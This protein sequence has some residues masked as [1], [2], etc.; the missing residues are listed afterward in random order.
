MLRLWRQAEPSSIL[1]DPRAIARHDRGR[2]LECGDQCCRLYRRRSGRKRRSCCVR[3]QRRGAGRLQPRP[4]AAGFRSF[5]FR[6][7]TCSTGARA[8]LMSRRTSRRRSM[9]MAAASLPVNTASALAIPARHPAHV[10]GL[11][12]LSQE[13]CPHDPAAGRRARALTIVAD[14]RG[15]P[16]AARDIA[17]ACLDIAMRCARSRDRAPYGIYHFA[18]AG[19]A[20]WFEFASAIVDM[21]A[22]RLGRKPR[23]Y[24]SAPSNTRHPRY[25]PPI[26]GSIARR[27]FARSGITL[28]PWR[29]SLADTIDRLLTKKDTP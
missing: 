26:A 12:P 28:R 14:Q 10:L 15:C 4:V 2:A 23:W 1:K 3:G 24:R 16:T 22:D 8:R 5:I 7:I 19:E 29:E 25:G 21:A 17:W 6:P 9:P 11:Q 27:S 20:S 13:F 18:G